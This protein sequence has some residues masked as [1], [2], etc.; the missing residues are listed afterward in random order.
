MTVPGS[1]KGPSSVGVLNLT[2]NWLALQWAC[3]HLLAGVDLTAG[4][5]DVRDEHD[6]VSG[7][8]LEDTAA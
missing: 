8:V 1:D 3:D 4:F 6:P 5:V 2:P 7:N